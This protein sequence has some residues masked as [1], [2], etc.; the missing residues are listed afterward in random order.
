VD[1]ATESWLELARVSILLTERAMRRYCRYGERGARSAVR[2]ATGALAV[3]GS[4]H[5]DQGDLSLEGDL[6]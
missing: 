2:H 1:I 6:G 5:P 4:D 3:H